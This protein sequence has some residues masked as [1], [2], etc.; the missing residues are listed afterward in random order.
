MDEGT[1]RSCWT[2]LAVSRRALTFWAGAGV[3]LSSHLL[4]P[5]VSFLLARF[6]PSAR[7]AENGSFGSAL[8]TTQYF[9]RSTRFPQALCKHL[10]PFSSGL[11]CSGVSRVGFEPREGVGGQVRGQRGGCVWRHRRVPQLS[12]Q[13]AQPFTNQRTSW[14]IQSAFQSAVVT[15]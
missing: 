5:A 3:L 7:E 15:L 8:Y 13:T 1:C 2:C 9:S 6:H 10:K 14:D 4:L 11:P 12:T